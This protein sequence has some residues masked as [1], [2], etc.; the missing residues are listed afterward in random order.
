[1]FLEEAARFRMLAE[2]PSFALVDGSIWGAWGRRPA[3]PGLRPSARW[4]RASSV[5]RVRMRCA[6]TRRMTSALQASPVRRPAWACSASEE[7]ATVQRR[8]ALKEDRAT[9]LDLSLRCRD[10]AAGATGRTCEGAVNLG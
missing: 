2:D 1:M 7:S 8:Q 3:V 6:G 9:S 10:G 5:L 4:S